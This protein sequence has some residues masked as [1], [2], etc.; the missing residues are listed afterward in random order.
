MRSRRGVLSA[1]LFACMILAFPGEFSGD[2]DL[3]D[4][5]NTTR[6]PSGPTP[7]TRGGLLTEIG[8]GSEDALLTPRGRSG[9]Y[10][11]Q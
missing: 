10:K 9:N 5:W 2:D 4:F 3:E 7:V 8:E 11:K 1:G 6:P